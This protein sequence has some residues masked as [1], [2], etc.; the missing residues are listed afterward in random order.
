MTIAGPTPKRYDCIVIGGGHNGL[1][2]AAYLARSRRRVL[3]LE[4]AQQ[5]GGAAVTRE[6]APGYQVSSCAHLLHLMPHAMM[7][8]LS[9]HAQGLRLAHDAIPTTALS[10]AGAPLSLGVDASHA[11]AWASSADALAYPK[12]VTRLQRLAGALRPVIANVPPRLGTDRWSERL[13][14]LRLAW[15]VRRLGRRDMRELLRIIGMNV[16]DLLE[17]HFDTP[18]LKGALGFDAVLG[19]SF[20]PRSPGTVLT[21]LYRLAAQGDGARIAQPVG[22]LGALTDALAKAAAAAGAQI[23][24][25]CAVGRIDVQDDRVRG[26][27]LKSG[28]AIAADVVISSCD[29][30]T[31]FLGLLG[32]EH[33][34]TG[35]V[36]RVTHLRTRGLAAKLHLAL[37]ELPAFVGLTP[38]ALAG[39]LIVAPSLEYI[40]RAYN[41]AKYGEFSSEPILEITMPTVNDASLAPPGKHVLSAIVQYAPYALAAGWEHERQRFMDL[42]IG[43]IERYAPGL[44]RAI[45]CAELLTPVDIEREFRITGGHWHHVDLAFDQFFMVRP[46]PG[47]AQYQT[48]VAG[49]YLC[50]AGC[51]PGGGVMGM[52]GRNAARQVLKKAA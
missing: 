41:H 15:H 17:E 14:L 30:Q 19:T 32:T 28:E 43:T 48:P 7:Q 42:A 21:L 36:R 44:R 40:E 18:L 22:G 2:C 11:L 12:Y 4:A 49:L 3:V 35:F 52:A 27:T 46:L 8:E 26:V 25:G 29:P 23:R 50:G 20:G 13:A 24:T 16:Y 31:T 33:L 45:T 9:L 5:V 6:F 1:V 39:R 10:P 37:D 51:H 38:A 47:A 34:D